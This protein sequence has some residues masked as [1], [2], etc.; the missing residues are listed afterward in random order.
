MKRGDE[1]LTMTTNEDEGNGPHA[2]HW[3]EITNVE[4]TLLHT[5]R[6][7]VNVKVTIEK[8]D[9]PESEPQRDILRD[10]YVATEMREDGLAPFI[11]VHDNL[12][13]EEVLLPRGM[14]KN[15][16]DAILRELSNPPQDLHGDTLESLESEWEILDDQGLDLGLIN[17]PAVDIFKR[18]ERLRKQVSTTEVE[19][20]ALFALKCE[21][22]KTCFMMSAFQVAELD[23]TPP[24]QPWVGP[25]S[26][27]GRGGRR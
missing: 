13:D 18:A 5:L 26:N 14:A 3:V 19:R 21:I 23:F 2:R 8:N 6:N 1:R 4:Y 10:W 7:S 25:K 15:V 12:T 11:V 9:E 17:S 24:P 22:A 16:A 27:R 20:L